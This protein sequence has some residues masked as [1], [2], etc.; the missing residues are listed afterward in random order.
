M[1]LST[2]AWR[3]EAGGGSQQ[4][5]WGRWTLLCLSSRGRRRVERLESSIDP[6]GEVALEAA[7]DLFHRAAFSSSSIHVGARFWIMDHPGNRGHVERAIEP[8]IA[9]AIQPV[10]SRV[11]RRC[12][13][14]THAGQRRE[15]SFV[16][17]APPV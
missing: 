2:L 13:D 15:G 9:S 17:Q 14:G 3:R 1:S 10:A 5:V 6:T 12:R 4:A 11:S 8:S 7:S 16:T